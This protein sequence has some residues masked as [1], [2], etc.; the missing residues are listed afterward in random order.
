[1]DTQRHLVRSLWRALPDSLRLATA[2]V[3]GFA[4][5]LSSR[6]AGVVLVYHAVSPVAADVRRELLPTHG[7]SLVEAQLRYLQANYEL[8]PADAI[9]DAVRARRRGQRF[10]AAVTFDD[11]LRTH[12]EVALPTLQRLG[13]PALFFLCGASLHAPFSF[14]WERLQRAVDRGLDLSAIAGGRDAGHPRALALR[15]EEGTP[16]E[17][18]KV[19]ERLEQLAGPDPPESGIRAA[20]A[21]ALGSGCYDVGFHTHRHD[22]LPPLDDIELA[23]ALDDGRHEL[24][25]VVGHKLTTIAYPHGLADVRVAQAAEAAGFRLGY[26]GTGEAVTSTSNPLL[27]SRIEPAFTGVPDLAGQLVRALFAAHR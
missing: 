13:I 5:R 12:A 2:R 4:L 24:E 25:Y 1:V 15:I 16:E 19:A 27:L 14:W 18:A 23:R 10:P 21:R 9:V 8:V 3:L 22:R 20:A 7:A 6:Q 11:D 17:R 26:T